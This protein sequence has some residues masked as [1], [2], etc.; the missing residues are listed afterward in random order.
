MVDTELYIQQLT[1]EL[2]KKEEK[3]RNLCVENAV[4]Y[5]EHH[6]L[7]F[8][9]HCKYKPIENKT[10]HGANYYAPSDEAE[11]KCPLICG[12]AYH[13]QYFGDY[14]SCKHGERIEDL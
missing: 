9:K 13:T 1:Y 6:G 2:R 12:D 14:F 4:L 11:E 8:C 10:N 3:I 7:V 5:L